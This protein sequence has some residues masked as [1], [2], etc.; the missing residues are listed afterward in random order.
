MAKISLNLGKTTLYVHTNIVPPLHNTLSLLEKK[1]SR[2]TMSKEPSTVTEETLTGRVCQTEVWNL[3][4]RG[5]KGIVS[6]PAV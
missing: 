1:H 3:E 2:N 6:N 4:E 5:Q